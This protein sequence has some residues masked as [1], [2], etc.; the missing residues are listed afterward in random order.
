MKTLMLG[1]GL[2]RCIVNNISW[3]GLLQSIADEYHVSIDYN[4]SFPMQ[5]ECIVNQILH[6]SKTP[7]DSIYKELKEKIAAK[8]KTAQLPQNSPHTVFTGIA[9]SFITTNYDF[10]LEQS[11]N[12]HFSFS[13]VENQTK[14]SNS[15]YNLMNSIQLADKEFFHI[16]GHILKPHTI[17]LGY[18]HYAGTLQHLRNKISTKKKSKDN[19]PAVLVG[20][21]NPM[22]NEEKCW[23]EKF[24]TDEIHIVGLG[25]GESEIDIW[26]LISYRSYLLYSNRFNA[27]KLIKNRIVFHDVGVEPNEKLRYMLVNNAVEYIF[28]HID[29]SDSEMYL[30]EYINIADSLR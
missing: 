11:V 15:K 10:L 25:L 16:H 17:C 22:I 20:L 6:L 4:V 27:K 29:T 1:N 5:F 7:S 2:N 23:A 26:W 28:H 14:N 8:L 19:T 24:F 30:Y 12:P 9:K 21:E 3:S 18:E 13:D